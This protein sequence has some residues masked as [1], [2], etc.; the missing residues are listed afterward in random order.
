[1]LLV[2]LGIVD[3]IAGVILAFFGLPVF[4]GNSI[5]FGLGI[6]MLIKGVISY[7]L[8]CAN[9]FYFDVMGILDLIAGVFLVL[10]F[11]GIGFFFFPYLGILVIIKGIYSSVVWLSHAK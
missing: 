8:A 9:R 6:L 3:V 7:L 11:Y 10:L 2:I 5:V 1:M 4:A